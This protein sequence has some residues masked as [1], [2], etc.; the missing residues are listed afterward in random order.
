MRTST[1]N[2]DIPVFTAA[3]KGVNKNEAPLY[4][5]K[6]HSFQC[7]VFHRSYESVGRTDKPVLLKIFKT[8]SMKDIL[9]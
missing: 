4:Q 9:T 7:A 1:R 8:C 3:Y 2:R 5:Q 6:Q